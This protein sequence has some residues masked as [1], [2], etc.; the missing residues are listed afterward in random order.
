[1]LAAARRTTGASSALF[2]LHEAGRLQLVTSPW[3]LEEATRNVERDERAGE[4]LQALLKVISTV[5]DGVSALAWAGRHVRKTKDVPVLASAAAAG[6]HHLATLDLADFG[7]IFE[8]PDLPV[9]VATPGVL[10]KVLA[11]RRTSSK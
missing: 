6:I 5:P 1:M 3:C 4:R 9:F 8:R 11:P 7:K 10:L 2:R